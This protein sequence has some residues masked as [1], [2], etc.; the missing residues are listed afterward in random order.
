[1]ARNRAVLAYIPLHSQA[2]VERTEWQEGDVQK[3]GPAFKAPRNV[4]SQNNE[5]QQ[6]QKALGIMEWCN[7][8]ML[9]LHAL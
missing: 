2:S 5:Q 4:V 9:F 6:Q 3:E 7:P 8:S 1:M